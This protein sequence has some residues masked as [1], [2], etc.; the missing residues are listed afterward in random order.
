MKLGGSMTVKQYEAFNNIWEPSML[1]F[2]G[3]TL[4]RAQLRPEG[5]WVTMEM[6]NTN[7]AKWEFSDHTR[8]GIVSFI[9]KGLDNMGEITVQFD[10]QENKFEEIS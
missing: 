10:A 7:G 5:Y 6:N 8:W 2:Y 4:I 9:S 1:Q 3:L